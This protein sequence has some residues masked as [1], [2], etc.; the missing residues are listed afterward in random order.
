MSTTAQ[1]LE[2]HPKSHRWFFWPGVFCLLF[3]ILYGPILV[4]LVQNWWADPDYGHGFLVPFF[5]AYV[6]WRERDK[7]LAAPIEPSNFGFVVMLAAVGL[8]IIGSLGAEVFTTRL[9]ILILL[10][11]MILFL[12]GWSTLRAVSFPLGFLLL[13]IPLPVIIYNQIAFPLQLFAS[14]CASSLLE[15]VGVPVLRDGNV[16][17]LSNYSLEVVEACS[18][19]RSLISLIAIA[20][21]YAYLTGTPRWIQRVLVILMVPIAIATNAVRI[22]GTGVL[23]HRFGATAAEGFLHEF[24]GWVV[25]VAALVLM[26][27]CHQILQQ[28]ARTRRERAHA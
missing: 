8:L 27:L 18:G 24:S 1:A 4:A 13:M 11:G 10:A 6:L 15:L 5:S 9:S 17:V 25:F 20:I 28:I 2:A 22:A 16:L 12:R 3:A 14:R 26:F 7:W 23:A 21:A 19:I